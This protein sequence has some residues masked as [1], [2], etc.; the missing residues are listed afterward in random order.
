MFVAYLLGEQVKCHLG[1]PFY[2]PEK[3][4]FFRR[5]KIKGRK[6]G[7]WFWFFCGAEKTL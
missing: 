2:I 3:K 1:E 4:L 7:E 5:K 6:K